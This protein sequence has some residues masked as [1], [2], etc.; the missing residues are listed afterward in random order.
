MGNDATPACLPCGMGVFRPP[1]HHFFELRLSPVTKVFDFALDEIGI[2]KRLLRYELWAR[3]VV[4]IKAERRQVYI[5]TLR[6][7]YIP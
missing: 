1:N 6:Y 4:S 2:I 5:Y 3:L 7:V